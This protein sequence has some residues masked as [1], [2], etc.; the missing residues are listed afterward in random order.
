MKK[1]L[2]A[3]LAVTLLMLTGCGITT[4]EELYERAQVYLGSNDYERATMLFSQLG[5]Y[6]D[7]AEY[8]LYARALLAWQEDDMTLARN[9]LKALHPFKSTGRYL[10]YLD[11]MDAAKAGDTARA[12]EGFQNLGTFGD[13][14][15]QAT[16]MQN[17]LRKEQAEAEEN[18][19]DDSPSD[20]PTQTQPDDNPQDDTPDAIL[21]PL[22]DAQ[23]LA[24]KLKELAGD[25]LSADY[26]L[27]CDA[28]AAGDYASAL[29]QFSA[30]GNT[31][32]APAWATVCRE[33]IYRLA[34][35]DYPTATL[36]NADA[37]MAQ[38]TAVAGYQQSDERM[39]DLETRFGVLL[40][41]IDQADQSPYL[42]YSPDQTAQPVLCRVI[43]LNH[44][45]AIL[46]A[47]VD[48]TADVT[49]LFSSTE[50]ADAETNGETP[51][52]SA[53]PL[54]EYSVS[55]DALTLTEGSGT[56]EDPFR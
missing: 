38:Y 27:A 15:Q 43:T 6:R 17:R 32:D 9:G 40:A 52:V 46:Q 41:L 55:L 1:N 45:C 22:L 24:Q 35:R 33:V 4:N 29:K 30:L 16:L 28:Y 26:E 37:L 42:L 8:A 49:S 20:A 10:A 53:E 7:S 19:D 51:D 21:T 31:L 13:S 11:A 25:A 12:L 34:E 50:E 2:I 39:L 44:D 48:E 23:E 54:P 18:G 47:T 14:A 5:E 56:Q 3:L 36:E